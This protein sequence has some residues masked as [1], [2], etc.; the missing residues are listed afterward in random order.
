MNL[1]QTS[2]PS[3]NQLLEIKQWLLE[4]E[5][6]TGNGFHCNWGIIE[7]AYASKELLTFSLDNKE[8]AFLVFSDKGLSLSIDIFE[9][10]P[11]QRSQNL[12]L[13][14]I[15]QSL[16]YFRQRNFLVVELFCQPVES[17][18]F[19]RECSFI[20]FPESVTFNNERTHLYRI[21]VES[22]MPN[23]SIHS[24]KEKLRLWTGFNYSQ[25]PTSQEQEWN[26]EFKPNSRKLKKPI[27]APV[28]SNWTL[29][30]LDNN[31]VQFQDDVRKFRHQEILFGS[32]LIIAEL[33]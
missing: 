32:F 15:N 14:V 17:E 26:L 12:G 6:E 11:Q 13:Q 33:E 27:I 9:V 21:L 2:R 7:K 8:I 4:E 1:I 22:Q 10:K 25:N 23:S 30:W 24:T 31:E 18:G 28:D 19:W 16:D 20:D 5:N 29:T 3:H